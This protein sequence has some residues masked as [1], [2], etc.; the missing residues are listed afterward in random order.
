MKMQHITIHTPKLDESVKF[1]EEI[2]GLKVVQELR[3]KGPHDIV[4]LANAEGETCVELLEDTEQPYGGSGL[5]I[6]FKA[7]D[8]EACREALIAQGLQV[9]P[10]I[11]PN[12]HVQFFFT[13]DPNGVEI[14]FI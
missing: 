6:G 2:V 8:V 13:K 3:G 5:S 10:M 4:F 1:Y 14:Q 12:P 9:T 7:D 11:Q